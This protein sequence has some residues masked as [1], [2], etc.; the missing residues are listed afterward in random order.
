M[1]RS[2]V[3]RVP[4]PH[5][6]GGVLVIDKPRGPTSHDV[7]ARL[8]RALGT[9]EIGHAGTLDPMATGVLVVAVGEGTKLAPYLSAADKAY[10]AT[11]ALGI[12]TDTLDADGQETLRAAVSAEVRGALAMP[13]SPVAPRIEEALAVERARTL[14]T[15][16]AYS[17][18]HHDGKRAYDLAR[19]GEAPV[20]ADRPVLVHALALL[21]SGA[22]ATSDEARTGEAWMTLSLEVGKGYYVRALARDL[23][24][25]LGTVGHLTALRRTR[26]GCFT[27]EE[28]IPL[29]TPA[30][31]IAARVLPLDHAAVRVLP[32]ARLTAVGARDARFG[33]AVR[34]ADLDGGAEGSGPSA[35]LDPEGVMVA[36]GIRQEDGTGN[37]VRGFGGGSTDG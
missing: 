1:K 15:P 31:E 32:V 26:S 17:A 35:W 34:A 22:D 36:V 37:V 24:A 29:D 30:E 23:A 28:A 10:E 9:R 5:E 16:P 11:L 12:A 14:Q 2:D 6:R 20:L 21:A 8:R 25:S 18:I 33:R 19:R 3:Q 27:L 4:R 13:A 7:V